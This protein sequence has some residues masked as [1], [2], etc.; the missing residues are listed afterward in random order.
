[1]PTG[2]TTPTTAIV[3]SLGGG[4]TITDIGT[5]SRYGTGDNA[6]S[7]P[8]NEHLYAFKLA[9]A[10]GNSGTVTDL[11]SSLTLSI[12]GATGRALPVAKPGDQI[13]VAAPTTAKTVDLVLLDGGIKQ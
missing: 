1:V 7:V 2:S 11:S 4:V 10:A 9:G 5:V 12:D 3:G 6:R 13:I 8:P